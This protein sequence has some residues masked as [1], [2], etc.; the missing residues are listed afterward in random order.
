MKVKSFGF[1]NGMICYIQFLSLLVEGMMKDAE[2]LMEYESRGQKRPQS[3]GKESDE[4]KPKVESTELSV[5]D[6]PST[7]KVDPKPS[8]SEQSEAKENIVK[9]ENLILVNTLPTEEKEE[10]NNP[11][12]TMTGSA[13]ATK[14]FRNTEVGL[15]G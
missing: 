13:P 3:H 15:T 4:K 12:L 9:E 6:Q 8:S 5:V 14:K 11:T 7:D 10:E 2:A 1:S